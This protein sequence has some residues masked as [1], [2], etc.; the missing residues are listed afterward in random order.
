[1]SPTQKLNLRQEMKIY[2]LHCSISHQHMESP[3]EHD[4]KWIE[5]SVR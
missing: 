3:R 2:G 5:F 1:M 4:E